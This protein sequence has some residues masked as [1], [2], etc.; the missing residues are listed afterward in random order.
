M[1][2]Y[3]YDILSFCAEGMS[4]VKINESSYYKQAG[5]GTCARRPV[6][7]SVHR[8]LN[9]AEGAFQAVQSAASRLHISL[10]LADLHLQALHHR[11]QLP[12]LSLQGGAL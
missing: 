2:Y 7:A 6:P 9:L 8:P 1:L 11:S 3:V 10:Q 12:I 5:Q 4:P